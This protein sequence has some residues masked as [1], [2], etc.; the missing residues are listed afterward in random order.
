MFL[1]ANR[2][3]AN[4]NIYS[5]EVLKAAAGEFQQHVEKYGPTFG[6]PGHV[7]DMELN[8]VS[9]MIEDIQYD[10]KKQGLIATIKMLPNA[11]SKNIQAIIRNGG[12]VG[13]SARGEGQKEADGRISKYSIKG[14]DFTLSPSTGI[15][16]GEKE[17][18][19]ESAALNEVQVDIAEAR[20]RAALVAG[21]KGDFESYKKLYAEMLETKKHEN[22]E[23][24]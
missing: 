23:R 10:D 17:I 3:T 4:G 21:Y 15:D 16:V 22:K 6:S 24:N 8:D 7:K 9:H 18:I 5:P 19:F 11:K 13:V 20:Y 14:C 12:R 2:K 1:M